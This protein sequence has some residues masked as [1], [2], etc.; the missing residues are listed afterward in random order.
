MRCYVI[1]DLKA[2]KFLP[3]YAGKM[4]FYLNVVDDTLRHKDDAPTI[5]LILCKQKKALSVEYALRNTAT[6]I[7]VSEYQL[8]QALPEELKTSLPTVAQLEAELANREEQEEDEPE[9]F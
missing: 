2:G 1:I 4:N 3:E 9:I 6:P 5:G 7:G 8:T